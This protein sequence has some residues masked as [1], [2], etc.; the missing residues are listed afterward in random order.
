MGCYVVQSIYVIPAVMYKT[1]F[2]H[3]ETVIVK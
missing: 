3:L 2:E 1:V